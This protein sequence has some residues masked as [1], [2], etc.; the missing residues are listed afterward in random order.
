MTDHRQH[1]TMQLHPSH[2]PAGPPCQPSRGGAVVVAD[3]G[4]A[5]CPHC[6]AY[7]VAHYLPL[8]MALVTLAIVVAGI[9]LW[10]GSSAWHEQLPRNVL[11]L[12]CG[13]MGVALLDFSHMLLYAGMPDFV[14]PSSAEKGIHFGFRSTAPERADLLAVLMSWGVRASPRY[15]P[16]LVAGV[17][18]VVAALHGLFLLRHSSYPTPST[19]RRPHHLQ[20]RFR[21]CVDGPVPGRRRAAAGANA[22]AAQLQRQWPVCCG[23]RHGAQRVFSSHAIPVSP[24]STT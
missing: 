23:M 9:H 4:S 14:T 17:L 15:A 24:T 7:K 3:R 6:P 5:R 20:D 11:V 22:P 18:L 2:Q 13:F 10:R 16:L 19:R 21:I 8:H 12:A 1:P